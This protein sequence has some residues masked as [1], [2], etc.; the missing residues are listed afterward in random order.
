VNDFS[1]HRGAILCSPRE[2]AA[3]GVKHMPYELLTDQQ[4]LEMT[5]LPGAP[6]R[7]FSFGA[8]ECRMDENPRVDFMTCSLAIDGGRSAGIEAPPGTFRLLDAWRNEESTGADDTEG[9]WFEWDHPSPSLWRPFLFARAADER[10]PERWSGVRFANW[11]EWMSS[12]SLSEPLDPVVRANVIEIH[13][14]LPAGAMILH[15]AA[16]ESRGLRAV[17]AHLSLR[18]EDVLDFAARMGWRDPSRLAAGLRALDGLPDPIGIQLDVGTAPSDFID[19]E[20]YL[21]SS[22]T[23]DVRWKGAL[24]WM[25]SLSGC[26]PRKLELAASWPGNMAVGAGGGILLRRV[27]FKVRVFRGGETVCKAYLGFS[28]RWLSGAERNES[29]N[30]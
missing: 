9:I 13:S 22:P 30:P 11:L 12:N 15:L 26:S 1:G 19:L 23:S 5:S 20:I 3:I 28:P 16:L 18:R 8:F 6:G 21:D 7:L 4:A 25:S 27:S 14:R 17:R 10:E 2:L 29:A 24:D